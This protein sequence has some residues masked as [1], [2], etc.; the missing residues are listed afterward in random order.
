M[1]Q[2]QL[3]L[4]HAAGQMREHRI[5]P[6]SLQF[7]EL[8]YFLFRLVLC[9]T[10]QGCEAATT[11]A[12]KTTNNRTDILFENLFIPKHHFFATQK[13]DGSKWPFSLLDEIMHEA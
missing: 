6:H 5:Q 8:E 13:C 1:Y 7:D 10:T 2:W 4:E 11:E 12:M 3:M 9:A